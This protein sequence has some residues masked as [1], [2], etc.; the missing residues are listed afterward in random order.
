MTGTLV[1]YRFSPD[2]IENAAKA[3]RLENWEDWQ[4]L[5]NISSEKYI[6]L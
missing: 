3:G 1:I 2:A 4:S 5:V 6:P